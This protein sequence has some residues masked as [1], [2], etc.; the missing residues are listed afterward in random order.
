MDVAQTSEQ[1]NKT[2]RVQIYTTSYI[3]TGYLYCRQRR[4]LDFL[5]GFLVGASCVDEEFLP[6]SK[7]EARFLD[8]RGAIGQVVYVNKAKILFLI[9]LN[10]DDTRGLGSQPEHRPYPFV[11]KS[12]VAVRLHM[13][14]YTLT[15]H[16]QCAEREHV[17]DILK[18]ERRFLPLTDAQIFDLQ[19]NTESASFLAI[20][21]QSIL[22]LEEL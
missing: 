6:V 19:G 7:A 12:A 1:I 4:L 21:K 14:G 3:C 11:A 8:G 18:S 5:N 13:P 9:E 17:S 16:V 2:V 10:D 15:G 20:S 22:V